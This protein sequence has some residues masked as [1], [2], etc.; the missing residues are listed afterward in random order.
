MKVIISG[1]GKIGTA[2]IESLQKE[3]HQIVAIDTNPEVLE[4]ISNRFDVLEVCGN[5]ACYDV[6]MEAGADTADLFISVTSSD[7]FNMLSCFVAKKIGV[8]NTVARIRNSEY[9][10]KSFNEV[11]QDLGINVTIN[12]ELLTAKS[13]FNIL[14]LPSATNVE[15]FSSNGTEMIELTIEEN[16]KVVGVPL[17]ELRKKHGFNFLVGVVEREG[18]VYIPKGSFTLSVGDKIGIFVQKTDE[19]S[20]L[21]SFGI[22]EKRIKSVMIIGASRISYYLSKLLL[23]SKR[24]VKIIDINEEKCLE[25]ADKLPNATVVNGDGM[26]QE[27]LIEEGVLD[28]DA[29]IALTG[30]DEQNVLSSIYSQSKDVKKTIAVI[31]RDEI[32]GVSKSLGL[33]TIIS[34][35]F[36]VADVLVRYAR[37]LESS[38]ESKIETLYS[39]FEGKAEASEFKILS[40]FKHVDVPLKNL[41]INDQT[42]IAGI[43]RD[44]ETIIPY[45]DDVFKVGDKV[46]LI[47]AGSTVYDLSDVIG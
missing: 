19:Q 6:L 24:S 12:P 5:G 18:A 40:D 9:N 7:E 28:T 47:T 17:F 2:I 41:K 31:D 37:A 35:K 38:K 33:D 39:L 10:T 27:L 32:I 4:S 30:K 15:T 42:L 43:I 20:V 11:K 45:G 3:N 1:C 21:K 22:E 8:K 13:L 25:Y 16:S 36:L 44:R 23:D 34:P 14:S 46:I 26:A 29:F